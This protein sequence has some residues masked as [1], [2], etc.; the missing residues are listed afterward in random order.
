VHP[1]HQSTAEILLNIHE[2]GWSQVSAPCIEHAPRS[3][4]TSGLD[5]SGE[6]SVD[7]TR[8]LLAVLQE[9]TRTALLVQVRTAWI[10]CLSVVFFLMCV[11][12]VLIAGENQQKVP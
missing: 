5:C 6:G 1:S 4:S 9:S 12:V 8:E 3:S 7:D 10:V 2:D 11:C